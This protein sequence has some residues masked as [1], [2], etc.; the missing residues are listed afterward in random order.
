[1]LFTISALVALSITGSVASSHAQH[2]HGELHKRATSPDN[3]CGPQNGFTCDP[4]SPNGGP[5]CSASGYCGK[6]PTDSA[7]YPVLT[8]NTRIW[9]LILRHRMSACIRHLRFWLW[10]WIQQLHR[11][12]P[13]KS[14]PH[15]PYK[16]LHH[17]HS[18]VSSSQPSSHQQH[19]APKPN[20][21][22]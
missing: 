11:S 17:H 5:C 18:P 15:Y 7:L 19:Q 16:V 20:T 13:G 1:M 4:S 2:Q 10:L 14:T 8:P 12:E 6:C 21:H 3:T 22:H 9:R